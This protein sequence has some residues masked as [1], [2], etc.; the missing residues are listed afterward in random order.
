MKKRNYFCFLS[1]VLSLCSCRLGGKF[2]NELPMDKFYVRSIIKEGSE[3]VAEL[4][5]GVTSNLLKKPLY[6]K[7][8]GKRYNGKIIAGDRLNVYYKDESKKK[9]DH[10]II[11]LATI[12]VFS[13][14]ISNTPGDSYGRGF[15]N[16]QKNLH[17]T[18][19]GGKSDDTYVLNK[20]N[21]CDP[22]NSYE[23]GWLV[24]GCYQEDELF[25][26]GDGSIFAA[27]S[28]HPRGEFQF[29]K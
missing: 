23:D 26:S 25:K 16:K 12:D 27:Y 9:I 7:D 20:D 4:K 5:C 11:S 22:L 10:I 18:Y 8:T 6:L 3:N 24:F 17:L 2:N 1:L 15:N 21:T 28:Y 19:D 13:L 14:S 29:T